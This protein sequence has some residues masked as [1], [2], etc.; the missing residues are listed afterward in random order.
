MALDNCPDRARIGW[1]PHGWPTFVRVRAEKGLN[2]IL[3]DSNDLA[4]MLKTFLRNC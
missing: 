3:L 2:F 1:N 4:R